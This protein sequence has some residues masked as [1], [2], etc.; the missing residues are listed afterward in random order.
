MSVDSGV[1][2]I[3]RWRP[4]L[5]P[6]WLLVHAVLLVGGFVWVYPFLWAVGSSLKSQAGF[7][8]EGLSL[9]PRELDWQNYVDAWTGA[10]FSTYF[11]NSVII[12]AGTVAGTLLLTSMAGYALARSSFPGKRVF[13]VVTVITLFLPRG[14]TIVP[15]YDLI[16]RLHLLNTLWSVVVVQVAGGMVFNTFLFMGYFITIARELDEAARVDGAGFN[17]IYWYVMLP[18]ARPMIATLGLFA[19]IGSWNDFFTPLVFTLGQPQLRTLPVGLYA[20]VSQ[21]S[22]NWTALCAGSIITLAPIVLVF[23]LAQRH[24][25]D[26]VAGAVKG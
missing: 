1:R 17:R 15:V 23:V 2:S 7:I 5:H 4:R 11:L 10:S 3:R 16:T 26:A 25:I 21:T 20:F 19:F 18:L 13:L 6:R 8:D 22:T 14:Y 24:V 9:V 12:T